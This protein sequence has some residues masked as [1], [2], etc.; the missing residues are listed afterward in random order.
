M[1]QTMVQMIAGRDHLE[2]RPKNVLQGEV[3]GFH[4]VVCP[5]IPEAGSWTIIMDAREGALPPAVSAEEFLK[6]LRAGIR[7]IKAGHYDGKKI[8]IVL[9]TMTGAAQKVRAVLDRTAEY[10]MRNGYVTCCGCCG[11]EVPAALTSINGAMDFICEEC[12][13]NI[14]NNLEQNRQEIKAK[15]GNMVTGLVGALFGA[16]LG[17]AVWVLI[18]QL[19]YIAGLAGVV[20]SVC[21]LKG[22]EKFGGKINIAGIIIS[23]LMTMAALYFAQNICYTIE[24]KK[25]L[26]GY[27]ITF[28][29]AYQAL[30]GLMQEYGEIARAYWSELTGG[31]LMAAA[32]STAIAYGMYK[33][34]SGAYKTERY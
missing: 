25:A 17:G 7:K 31:L 6:E 5:D 12:Y 24:L 19:G 2:E 9:R 26:E 10:F 16:L 8:T 1:K 14:C 30:P 4:T 18:Y 33:N 27:D 28:F 3:G 11:K 34:K 15:K 23:I 32:S 20:G 13:S 21:A 22:Y 29:E